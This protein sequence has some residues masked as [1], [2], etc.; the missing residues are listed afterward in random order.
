MSEEYVKPRRTARVIAFTWLLM[1]TVGLALEHVALREQ[2]TAAREYA[3]QEALAATQ[4][5]VGALQTRFEALADLKPLASKDFEA[6]QIVLADRLGALQQ[7]SA[8]N[9]HAEALDPITERIET[10]EKQVAKVRRTVLAPKAAEPMPSAQDKALLQDPP[11]SII[12][13][14]LRGGER[15]LSI[16]PINAQSVGQIRVLRPGES[17]AHWR[18]E[19]LDATNAHFNVDGVA[20]RLTLR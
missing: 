5:Q 16:A 20:R 19:S 13:T 8:A 12:G 18:L 14:E 4:N 2:G 15:F 7:A 6:A 11:F 17:E 1:L 10:L 3:G 9:L